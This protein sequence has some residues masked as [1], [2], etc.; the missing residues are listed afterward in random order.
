[1]N[2]KEEI[3]IPNMEDDHD[4]LNFFPRVVNVNYN[5]YNCSV[6]SRYSEPP[7]SRIGSMRKLE[8]GTD[9]PQGSS[10][11]KTVTFNLNPEI[12]LIKSYKYFNRTGKHKQN[13][14]CKIF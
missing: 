3:T 6:D 1:M 7:G 5:A 14:E 12:V 8:N 9:Y 10:T 11:K 2:I 13:C 4:D